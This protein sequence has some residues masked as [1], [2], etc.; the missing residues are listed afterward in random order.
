MHTHYKNFLIQQQIFIDKFTGGLST[1]KNNRIMT[2]Q[3]E[4]YLSIS[5]GFADG[6]AN[7]DKF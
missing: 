6:Q 2:N 1:T 3:Y 4:S 5:N 7:V